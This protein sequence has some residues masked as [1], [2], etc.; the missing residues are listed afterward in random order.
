MN[1]FKNL[2]YIFCPRSEF[3][4]KIEILNLN[5]NDTILLKIKNLSSMKK[6]Q[7]SDLI[8]YCKSKFTNKIIVID[9]DQVTFT[10][11]K[12]QNENHTTII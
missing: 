12:E 2:K 10:I 5:K 4:V 9:E 7:I 1:I 3:A 11:I 8:D 6:S